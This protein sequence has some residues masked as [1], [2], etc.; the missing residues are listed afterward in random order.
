MYLMEGTYF[1]WNRAVASILKTIQVATEN[2]ERETGWYATV[3]L[4]GIDPDTG[5][6]VSYV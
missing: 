3:L 2:I 5:E 1:D 6:I 4:G